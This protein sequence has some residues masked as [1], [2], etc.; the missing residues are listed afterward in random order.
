MYLEADELGYA[1]LIL[2]FLWK[3][4]VRNDKGNKSLTS[5][6]LWSTRGG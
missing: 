6:V 1:H 2:S 4:H 5:S 3:G